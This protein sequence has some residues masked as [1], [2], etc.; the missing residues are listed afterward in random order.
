M[1]KQFLAL[2][3]LFSVWTKPAQAQ[4]VTEIT[5]VPNG[6]SYVIDS[7]G[8][9]RLANDIDW[10]GSPLGLT[11]FLITASNVTLNLNGKTVRAVGSTTNSYNSTG[12]IAEGCS[13]LVVTNGALEGF[14]QY[15]VS[16]AAVTQAT[17]ANLHIRAIGRSNSPAALVPP[18]PAGFYAVLSTNVTLSNVTVSNVSGW[19]NAQ[20]VAGVAATLCSNFTNTGST[21]AGVRG[22]FYPNPDVANVNSATNS[23]SVYGFIS[24]LSVNTRCSNLTVRSISADLYYKEVAGISIAASSNTVISGGSVRGVTNE[25]GTAQGILGALGNQNMTVT[26][27]QVS[28]IRTGQKWTNNALAHTALGI[29]FAPEA[30]PMRVNITGVSVTNGG[31][32]Y[33]SAPSVTLE[34]IPGDPGS[35]ATAR[36][37]VSGGKVSRV[38]ILSRGTNYIQA[39]AVKFSGG[40]GT[41]AGAVILPS[42]T[43]YYTSNNV[44]GI[45]VV[46]CVI[47]NVVGGIDDAHGMSLFV[48]TNAIIQNVRVS[49]V[50]DGANTLRLSASKATGIESYGNPMVADSRILL[51]NCHVENIVADSPGDLAASGFSAA[52]GGITF[53]G[54]TA[55]NVRV[56]G[57]NALTPG[58]SPGRG[59][60]FGWAPDIRIVF[61]YPAWNVTNRNCTAANCDVGFDTF[62]YQNSVWIRPTSRGNR[63]AF[64]QQPSTPNRPSGTVRVLY[65]AV[66]NELTDADSY[67]NR[68]K[69]IQVWN[70]AF[71]NRI[72]GPRI[73]QPQTW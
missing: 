48:V 50:R 73:L 23:G 65:G 45:R 39:P 38:E 35:G 20:M 52:G 36:A 18:F 58:A 6:F 13:N 7:P 56:I 9:F 4:A 70:N 34:T 62:N 12:V 68:V 55:S 40:G 63:L 22:E 5:S 71:G 59:Y 54:C 67:P 30:R 29:A 61:Q 51:N 47:S 21:I 28:H 2:A 25:G 53:A 27:V 16:V 33:A 42:Q 41:K 26:N 66:W 60:G 10:E 11:P 72:L 14:H 15:G 19:T 24:L 43:R 3:L 44:G 32:G 37:F 64:L 31:R 49:H 46:D 8:T 1:L 57:T 17:F 69:P